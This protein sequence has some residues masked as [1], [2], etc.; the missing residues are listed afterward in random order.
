MDA[1]SDWGTEVETRKS[2]SGQVTLFNSTPISWRSK[3]Q[4]S[5]ALFSADAEYMAV[6]EF[7]KEI[8]FLQSLIRSMQDA[9]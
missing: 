1:D 4:Q 2:I 8:I 6:S 7:T 9:S 5:I 3:N